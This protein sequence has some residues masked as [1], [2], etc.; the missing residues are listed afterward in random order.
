MKDLTELQRAQLA[1]AMTARAYADGEAIIT[2]GEAGDTFFI[3]EAGQ[4]VVSVT[5]GGAQLA[6]ARLHEG[7]QFGE[8]ALLRDEPRNATVT[9]EGDC[10]CLL[11][12]R[13]T[14][15]KHVQKVASQLDLSGSTPV[16]S[17]TFE[18]TGPLGLQFADED[19]AE[20]AHANNEPPRVSE[21]KPGSVASRVP[22]IRPGLRLHSVDGV[23]D[24]AEWSAWVKAIVSQ[25][26]RQRGP[27]QRVAIAFTYIAN[28]L[29]FTVRRVVWWSQR[30]CAIRTR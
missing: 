16:I 22:G 21:V 4:A 18:G 3:L 14:F 10:R 28:S 24:Y 12:E 20:G 17:L 23:G 5:Q 7:Q 27:R 11:L 15:L 19:S 1:K 29:L 8:V 2:Q 13:A 6:V 26:R 30:G 9:A 25:P